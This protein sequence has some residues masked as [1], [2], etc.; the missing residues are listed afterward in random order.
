MLES[1]NMQRTDHFRNIL[2]QQRN[3]DESPF[4]MSASFP[5]QVTWCSTVVLLAVSF[6]CTLTSIS[7]CEQQW[8]DGYMRLETRMC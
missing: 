1:R 4:S 6:L 3:F 2:N 7:Q 8:Q 5:L